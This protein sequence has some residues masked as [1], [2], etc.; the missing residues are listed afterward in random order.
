MSKIFRT[1]SSR[2]NELIVPMSNL[3][4][5]SPWLEYNFL[6]TNKSTHSICFACVHMY[7]LPIVHQKNHN[8]QHRSIFKA[9]CAV[10]RQPNNPNSQNNDL[11]NSII[12]NFGIR[13]STNNPSVFRC[14]VPIQKCVR[15][16]NFKLRQ[17]HNFLHAV[18]LQNL[19]TTPDVTQF[20]FVVTNVDR[21]HGFLKIQFV[22][23][24]FTI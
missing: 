7:S 10:L 2:Q 20:A 21:N 3:T 8:N 4:T 23:F 5:E 18:F 19:I 22:I 24:F 15:K 14:L 16:L 17:L 12:V 9:M 6:K 1:P 11:T 13:K